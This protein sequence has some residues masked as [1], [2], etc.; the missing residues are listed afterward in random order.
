MPSRVE[1]VRAEHG[2]DVEI[3]FGPDMWLGTYVE[4]VTGKPMIVW[5]GE[6]HVHAGIKPEDINRMRAQHPGSEFLIHP[7][8][9]CATQCVEYVAAG[10]IVDGSVHVLGTSGMLKHVR[11]HPN[12]DF[13]AQ[14]G[15]TG[16]ADCG[17]PQDRPVDPQRGL[18]KELQGRDGPALAFRSAHGELRPWSEQRFSRCA[19]DRRIMITGKRGNHPLRRSSHNS[20]PV[21]W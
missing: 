12:G 3:L 9:G 17:Q 15:P 16:K 21:Q 8:C 1:R 10:E 2:E 6:C 11:E 20:H 14:G 5:P 19:P 13:A 4:R 7:E 18:A